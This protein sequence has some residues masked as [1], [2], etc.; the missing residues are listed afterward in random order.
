VILLEKPDMLVTQTS[1]EPLTSSRASLQEASSHTGAGGTFVKVLESIEDLADYTAEMEDLVSHSAIHN[2]FY[3]PWIL[4]PIARACAD[5]QRLVFVLVFEV[6]EQTQPRLLGFFPF[7]RTS[8]HSLVP[9]SYLRTWADPF[10]YLGRGDPLVR[11]GSETCVEAVLDWFQKGNSKAQILSLRILTGS[12]AIPHAIE[13]ALT[14]RPGLKSYHTTGESHLYKRNVSASAYI[15]EI[16]S[17]KSQQT[18]RRSERRL[19]DIGTFEYSDNRGCGDIDIQI[20]EFLDLESRGWKGRHGV[21]VL[22]YGHRDLIK[23]ILR[24][25]HQRNRL[26]LLTLRIG[27]QLIAARCVILSP[28]GSF[29]FKL[30]YDE[31]EAYAQRSPGLL[32]EL[33]AIR[34]LHSDDDLLGDGIKW[35][36]TCAAPNSAIFPRTRSEPL[37][38]HRHV[39]ARRQTSAS[40][41]LALLPYAMSYAKILRERWRHFSNRRGRAG[42]TQSRH[43]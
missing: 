24:E 11:K 7:E 30:T 26:S 19:Q 16:F 43:S 41:V 33:E 21:A 32:L 8:L 39:I 22:S 9:L 35:M 10:N 20:D 1:V 29:L 6:T 38:I 42:E 40:I 17:R 13:H 2:P 23:G 37:T 31:T 15:D 36:D 28:P 27:G 3:E 25:A 14:A 34:R 18:M 12:T 4:I 5:R